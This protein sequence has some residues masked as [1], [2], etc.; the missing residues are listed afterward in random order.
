MTGAIRC[1]VTAFAVVVLGFSTG[2]AAEAQRKRAPSVLLP[3]ETMWTGGLPDAPAWAPVHAEGRLFVALQDGHVVAVGLSDGEV[4]WTIEQTVVAQPAI[5]D[6]RLFVAGPDEL[7]ALDTR[8][9]G[10]FWSIPLEAPLSAP[11]V[12]DM[13]WLIATL[14]GGTVL[15]LR[16]AD[17]ETVWRR[18]LDASIDVPPA[19]AGD[20]VYVSLTNGGLAALSLS[21]GTSVWQRQLDGAPQEVLPLDD[22]FVGAGDHNFYRLSH[23]DGT[24][25][26]RWPTG[27]DIVGVPTVDEKRV[28][29]S[30]L[31][32]VVWALD[33]ASGVQRWR[34]PLTARPTAGPSYVG[35]LL[36][37]G[38]LSRQIAFYEPSDGTLYGRVSV[39]TDLAFP[40]LH[41]DGMPGDPT[42][43]FV[44][45]DGRLQALGP[46]TVPRVLDPGVT[47]ILG[48]PQAKPNLLDEDGISDAAGPD[49]DA[50]TDPGATAAPD[51]ATAPGATAGL[52]AATDPGA[53]AGLDAA[54]DPGAT[55]APDAATDPSATAGLDAATDPGATAGLDAA[56]DPGATAG[57]EAA[58]DLGTTAEPEA[59]ADLG[60][61]ADPGTTADP[62][63]SP[64]VAAPVN[65]AVA[66][67]TPVPPLV[68]STADEP[69]SDLNAAPAP[70]GAT[71]REAQAAASPTP[72]GAEDA[73]ASPFAGAREYAIQ[74]GAFDNV[75]T[76]VALADEL[77]DADYP[78]YVVDPQ[79]GDAPQLYRVRI[80]DFP[81]RSSAETAGARIT[82]DQALAWH[83]VALP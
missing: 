54:T 17:G 65:K 74:V 20:R 23:R 78:A 43:V 5:G 3:L 83:V 77:A 22:L 4:Q 45:G 80:G 13:Q 21:D 60:A 27:G 18:T 8:T 50:A 42:L 57:R 34:Q 15:A 69:A 46:S 35:D 44:T 59:A 39:P 25:Q 55:A 29:F 28:F 67:L 73:P 10:R 51:A 52:D 63:A 76:A 82:D 47:P 14:E 1:G 62:D 37:F 31:D 41:L 68:L 75:G 6:W 56:T 30:S 36:V 70:A 11:L 79:P 53:T 32:N 81:D 66:V 19:V 49:R 40:P 58:A 24:E 2:G 7:M 61:A 33:R 72:V 64:E 26:W 48:T 16:G 9:G 12:W 71:S 38:G